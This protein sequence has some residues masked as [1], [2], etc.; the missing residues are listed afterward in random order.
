MSVKWSLLAVA[1]AS[2]GLL[3]AAFS[4]AYADGDGWVSHSTQ[5]ILACDVN[6]AAVAKNTIAL[7]SC[8]TP[9]G[10]DVPVPATIPVTK[11]GILE[12]EFIGADASTSA[13]GA[14]IES[15]EVTLN[16]LDSKGD[17][18]DFMD[19]A[20]S[21]YAHVAGGGTPPA[22][23]T[24]GTTNS[25]NIF[26]YGNTILKNPVAVTFGETI[27]QAQLQLQEFVNNTTSSGAVANGTL[28]VIADF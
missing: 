18:V 12:I 14:F 10:S 6:S 17:Q 16:F 27:T 1:I 22:N 4:S 20:F 8:T 15:L 9:L 13:P 25:P 21:P 28:R 3:T 24:Y 2:I 5:Y 23:I 26:L 11:K 19:V 7:A